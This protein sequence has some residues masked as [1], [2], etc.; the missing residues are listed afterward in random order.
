MSHKYQ[1]NELVE[2]LGITR[3]AINR[4][5]SK[6]S[7]NTVHEYINGRKLKL[8]VLSSEE[9]EALKHEVGVIKQKNTVSSNIH[10]TFLNKTPNID[11]YDE[12]PKSVVNSEKLIEQVINL[13][14]TVQ[15][16]SNTVQQYVDRIINAEKQVYLLENLENKNQNEYLRIEAQNKQLRAKNED[17]IKENAKLKEEIEKYNN[18]PW[19]N[20]RIL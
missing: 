1:I 20:K 14:E 13:S 4:K 6:Y 15:K 18:K 7:F 19:W 8:I 17:L 12:L 11:T 3:T 2:I 9:L 16:Q 10:D 5:I